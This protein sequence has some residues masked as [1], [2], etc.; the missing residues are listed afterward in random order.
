MGLKL[1]HFFVETCMCNHTV[2]SVPSQVDYS[3]AMPPSRPPG[4]PLHV[5]FVSCDCCNAYPSVYRSPPLP[6]GLACLGCFSHGTRRVT[7][8]LF[9]GGCTGSKGIALAAT[10]GL[11]APK[12]LL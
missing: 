1:G 3:P 5:W 9:G 2:L 11:Y 4:V 6:R 7:R 10:V 12:G 8:A